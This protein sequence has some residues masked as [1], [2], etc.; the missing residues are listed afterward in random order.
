MKGV[1]KVLLISGSATRINAWPIKMSSMRR[2]GIDFIIFRNSL[3]FDAIPMLV[4]GNSV[5][6][7]GRI[8]VPAGEG[9]VSF[10]LRS[11]LGE[12]IAK[13]LL[14][15]ELRDKIVPLTA[16]RTWSLY[17]VAAMLPGLSGKAV[18]NP[19]RPFTGRRLSREGESS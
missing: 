10:A 14:R 11:D 9:R 12:A 7:S 6:D 13:A 17:D 1:E 3:Y 2:T 15:P 8:A 5:F 18:C 19:F 4:G 16:T